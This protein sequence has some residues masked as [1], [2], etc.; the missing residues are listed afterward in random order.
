MLIFSAFL[1][2]LCNSALS[3]FQRRG[4]ETAEVRRVSSFKVIH[5]PLDAVHEPWV[6]VGA[7]TGY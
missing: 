5:N 1:G 4:A 7:V 3:S 2:V 6:N